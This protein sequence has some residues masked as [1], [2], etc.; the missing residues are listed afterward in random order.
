MRGRPPGGDP[1]AARAAPTA[2]MRRVG[3]KIAVLQRV[4]VQTLEMKPR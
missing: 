3:T 1:R 2:L 4:V